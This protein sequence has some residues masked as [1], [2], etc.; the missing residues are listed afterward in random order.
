[1]CYLYPMIRRIVLLAALVAFG[2]CGGGSSDVSEG[3]STGTATGAATRAVPAA[4][5]PPR[6]KKGAQLFMA[7]CAR[8]HGM[9][10]VPDPGT[11]A[12]TGVKDLTQPELQAR[13]TDDEIRKQIVKGSDN[14]Q[15]PSF[16][17]VFTDQQIEQILAHVRSLRDDSKVLP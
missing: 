16:A 1:M 3:S 5:K 13:L 15:M 7:N 9:K 14:R 2:A 17:G 8:C 4:K 12:R 11:A 6:S 10:G